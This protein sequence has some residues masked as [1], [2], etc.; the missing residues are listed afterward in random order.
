MTRW[1]V[2]ILLLALSAPVS[3]QQWQVAREQFAFAGRQ[4]T[5][6]VD[7]AGEGTIRVI[8]GPAGLVRVSGRADGGLTAAGLS[9]DEHLTLT[10]SG[11]GPVEYVI[12]VPER[13]RLNVHFPDRPGVESMGAMDRSRS[14]HWGPSDQ[15]HTAGTAAWVPEPDRGLGNRAAYTVFTASL[16]P[17]T[18]AIPDLRNVRAVTVRVEGSTFRIGASRPLSLSRGDTEYIEIR[19]AGPPMELIVMIPVGTDHFMLN[20]A[21][22]PAMIVQGEQVSVL[23]SPN[24]RQWL[25]GGRGWVTFTPTDGTLRCDAQQR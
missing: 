12:A 15:P 19:P 14:F 10:G 1:S 5:V 7:M 4:L 22:S 25:S 17:R 20:T 8:R 11:P 2:P 23:C 6:H 18:V 3:A 9:S 13:V 24:T 16:A 21:G